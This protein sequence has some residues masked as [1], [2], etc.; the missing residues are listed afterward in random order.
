MSTSIRQTETLLLFNICG[1]ALLFVD[2]AVMVYRLARV[3]LL[4]QNTDLLIAL[5][6]RTMICLLLAYVL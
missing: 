4:F 6:R 1:I 3:M 5:K 2:E